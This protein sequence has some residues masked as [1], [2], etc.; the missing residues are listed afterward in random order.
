MSARKNWK[1]EAVVL[2]DAPAVARNNVSA[3]WEDKHWRLSWD[4]TITRDYLIKQQ[5]EKVPSDL[6]H[7]RDILRHLKAVDP[8]TGELAGY[9]PAGAAC[10]KI[11][12]H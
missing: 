2:S 12:Q 11:R 1:I 10:G 3:F 6:L 7:R 5:S 8:D 4:D 9:P